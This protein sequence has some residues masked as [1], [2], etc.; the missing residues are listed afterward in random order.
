M[1]QSRTVSP[2][3]QRAFTLIELLVVMAI[4]SLLLAIAS[5][6][7]VGSLRKSKDVVLAQ[8]LQVM[9][10]SLDK[11]VGD[12]GRYPETL[13]E[14]VR[15]HYLRSIP[16]DPVTDSAATWVLVPSTDADVPGIVDVK[17]GASGQT[18]EG[19]AYES[20]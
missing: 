15:E 19:R 2:I 13:D 4:I 18:Y 7:F 12:K 3:G 20:L 10:D 11:F 14:L 1:M 9:R 5:P 8:D 17:S 16:V 6:R